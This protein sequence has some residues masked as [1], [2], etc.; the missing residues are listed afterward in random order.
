MMEDSNGL[1]NQRWVTAERGKVM[2]GRY[3]G[4]L[5]RAG[6]VFDDPYIAILLPGGGWQRLEQLE[7]ASVCELKNAIDQWLGM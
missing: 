5:L 3:A 4:C 6:A 1:I 2:R 7:G